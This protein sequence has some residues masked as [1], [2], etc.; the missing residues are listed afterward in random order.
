MLSSFV[1]LALFVF[2][3]FEN[4]NRM[5]EIIIKW[6]K[7]SALKTF[8]NKTRGSKFELNSIIF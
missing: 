5:L 3:F 8:V 1:H 7:L 4:A 6:V 2:V